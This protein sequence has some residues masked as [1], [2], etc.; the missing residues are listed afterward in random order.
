MNEIKKF[1]TLDGYNVFMGRVRNLLEWGASI[2]MTA[3]TSP[4]FWEVDDDRDM[5]QLQKLIQFLSMLTT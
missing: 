3:K 1:S 4:D 2:S 5:E